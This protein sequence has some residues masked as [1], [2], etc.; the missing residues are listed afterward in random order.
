MQKS[1]ISL[2]LL[3]IS[4]LAFKPC[5]DECSVN[6][7][8]KDGIV[9]L[10]EKHIENHYND[11]SPLCNCLCC[12]TIVTASSNYNFSVFFAENSIKH[13]Y[14]YMLPHYSVSPVSPPPRT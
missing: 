14:N 13:C 4:F 5:V 11:C 3:Y 7:D 8:A 6:F 9:H 10:D 12:N 2:L 1:F